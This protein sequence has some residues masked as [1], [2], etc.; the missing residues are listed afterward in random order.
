MI[1]NSVASSRERIR[2]EL[3]ENETILWEGAP[4]RPVLKR[5]MNLF[6]IRNM[7][8]FLILA[9]VAGSLV[10]FDP[11]YAKS[12]IIILVGVAVL[13]IIGCA[14]AWSRNR[15]R[16]HMYYAM[17][18]KRL[19][20]LNG[21]SEELAAWFSPC[22]DKKDCKQNGETTTIKLTDSELGFKMEFYAV[23]NVELLLS[24]LTP[25]ILRAAQ[26]S[27][28]VPFKSLKLRGG[29]LSAP[30]LETQELASTHS[31]PAEENLAA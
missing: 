1:Q 29:Q 5:Q 27:E 30:K 26:E 22:I 3:L 10:L 23:K 2:Q 13:R 9:T 25:Y 19:M 8:F 21:K 7:V 14:S 15:K 28:T 12:G 6:I 11:P 31:S 24:T 16:W 4:D 17:T 18:N 20:S